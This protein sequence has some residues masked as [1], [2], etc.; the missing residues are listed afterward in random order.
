[1]TDRWTLDRAGIVNVFQYDDEVLHFADGRLLLRGVNGSGKSTAMNMLLPFLLE[2]DVRRIDAAGEQQGV[3]RSWM[4]SGRD[5]PQPVG[6]LWIE[7]RRNGDDGEHHLVC[8]CGIKANRSTDRVTT[9]WFLTDRRPGVDLSL[10]TGRHP[11]STD[12]L[13][14]ELGATAVFTH[15]QRGS[16]REAVRQ[17][18]Y[19]GAELDRHLRLLHEVRSPRVGDRI[20]NDLT[21]Y[22]LDALPQLSDRAIDDAA[23]PLENLEEFRRNV[24]QLTR[25][26]ATLDALSETYRSYVRGELRRRAESLRGL[27]RSATQASR[28]AAEAEQDAERARAAAQEAQ[29]RS[30]QLDQDRVQAESA[31]RALLDREEYKEGQRLDDLRQRVAD[32]HASVDGT[33]QALRHAVAAERRTIEVLHRAWRDADTRQR[34]LAEVVQELSSLATLAGVSTAALLAPALVVGREG[35]EEIHPAGDR[36]DAEAL[37]DAVGRTR[38]AVLVRGAEVTELRHLLDAAATANRALE[39]AARSAATAAEQVAEVAADLSTA[40]ASRCCGR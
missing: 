37:R 6:Y 14:A 26:A 39:D 13:R 8:G 10:V 35:T 7:F 19:G 9:W 33:E 16:Y 34:Q 21:G 27:A 23:Q 38:S 18:L 17:Q 31:L 11:L 2:A 15:E 1:M 20:S 12:A 32:L 30:Q 24:E 22:L 25:T 40:D 3:L 4:L 29:H 36:P 28:A 5:E